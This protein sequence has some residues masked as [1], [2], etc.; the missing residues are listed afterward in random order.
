MKKHIFLSYSKKDREFATKLGDDLTA[1]GHRIWIDRSL[2]VG[3]DWEQTIEQ[4]LNE[5]SDVIVVLSS[6]ALASEWV[7]HEG[8][9][10]YAL[11]KQIFPVLIEDVTES[12]P[13][14]LGKTQCH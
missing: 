14:W 3:S 7:R 13:I 8:S 6:H 12:L 5:A 1:A 9:M 4:Q 10:A 11:K 2:E